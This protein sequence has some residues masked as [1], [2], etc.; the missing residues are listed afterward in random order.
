MKI[1]LSG[2]T[3]LL[4]ILILPVFAQATEPINH[5]AHSILFEIIEDGTISNKSVSLDFDANS[6][7]G[8]IWAECRITVITTDN[9]KKQVQTDNYYTSTERGTIRNLRIAPDKVSF[10]II[11]YSLSPERPLKLVADR[12]DK[13]P[14]YSVKVVGL[15]PDLL[16]NKKSVQIEWRQGVSKEETKDNLEPTEKKE[17]ER[18]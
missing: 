9:D 13:T 16:T 14:L 3:L 12:V 10:D 17:E 6:V 7:N 4:F 8:F 18:K 1:S 2:S 15:W 11:P 5:S